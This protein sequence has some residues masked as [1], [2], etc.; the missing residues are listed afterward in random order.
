M[1][2]GMHIWMSSALHAETSEKHML[3]CMYHQRT[4]LYSPLVISVTS[5]CMRRRGLLLITR[6]R[7]KVTVSYTWS[8]LDF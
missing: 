4:A 7:R 5:R 8:K 1:T 2:Q 6:R 3:P